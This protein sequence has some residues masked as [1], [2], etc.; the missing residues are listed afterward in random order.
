LIKKPRRAHTPGAGR[1]DA[2]PQRPV[3]CDDSDPTSVIDIDL[4][5]DGVNDRVI[6]RPES[7][8]CAQMPVLPGRVTPLRGT[9]Q[10]QND[11]VIRKHS[12]Q[13]LL[14]QPTGSTRAIAPPTVGTTAHN[15]RAVDDQNLHSNSVSDLLSG[16]L[17]RRRAHHASRWRMP[18]FLSGLSAWHIA[19]VTGGVPTLVSL[20]RRR[21][22]HEHLV[23][24][25]AADETG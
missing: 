10:N 7:V 4:F 3:G 25:D 23:L 18:R 14:L 1:L 17:V 21:Q 22:R 24:T 16:S 13:Q 2:V 11:L 6:P 5:D 12:G 20:D 8:D 9:F 19:A 15:V